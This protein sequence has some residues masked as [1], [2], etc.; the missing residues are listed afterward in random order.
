MSRA[1]GRPSHDGGPAWQEPEHRAA[2]NE[3]GYRIG[4]IDAIVQALDDEMTAPLRPKPRSTSKHRTQRV[5]DSGASGGMLVGA[6]GRGPAEVNPVDVRTVGSWVCG[7]SGG[8]EVKQTRQL[9][10]VER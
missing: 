9:L 10:G 6:K 4:Q 3:A 1:K 8:R 5:E 7:F 2:R